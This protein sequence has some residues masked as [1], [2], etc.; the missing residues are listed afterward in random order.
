M[1]D[2][3]FESKIQHKSYRLG[4]PTG[5]FPPSLLSKF[6]PLGSLFLDSLVPES[7]RL[8]K[9]PVSFILASSALLM[10]LTVSS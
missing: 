1:H 5:V 9:T 7:M 6:L 2:C 3:N 4:L 8:T 10:E